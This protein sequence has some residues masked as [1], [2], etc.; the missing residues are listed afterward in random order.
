MRRTDWGKLCQ[1]ASDLNDNTPCVLLDK[2]NA[3]LNNLV[4]V[5]EFA[6]NTTRW[7]ARIPLHLGRREQDA[8]ALRS[9][10][11]TMQ[12]IHE[13]CCSGSSNLLL[14]VPRIFAY[15]ADAENPI[16]VPFILMEFLSADTAMDSAGGYDVHRGAIPRAH[17]PNLYRSV[18]QCHVHLTRLRFPKIGTVTRCAETGAF[19]I[20]PLPRIGGPF[21]TAS[22]FFAAWAERVKFKGKGRGEIIRMMPADPPGLAERVADAIES[23]PAQVRD[24]MAR[25]PPPR[26]D[27]PFPLVHTDFLHSNMLVD[28]EFN[29]V[30][31]IDWEG[32]QTVPW[33]CVTFPGFLG[34]MPPSFDLPNKYDESG[35]P[36]DEKTRELW[37]ERRQ[38]I[39]LVKAAESE[40]AVERGEHDDSLSAYL[41][42]NNTQALAYAINA[43]DDVGKLGFYDGVVDQLRNQ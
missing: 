37:E 33:E 29:L 4:R 1:L 2:T 40:A 17:R 42:D 30:G 27:G 15:E 43:Y 13:R 34:C 22:A 28:T 39:E 3:G 19:D 38:Y 11:H 20:G 14:P 7:I 8:T 24:L 23:F 12:L 26:N 21:E 16:G 25:R 32:A 36:L 9:E 35:Q 10:V 6:D 5:L 31:V 18:A 41:G